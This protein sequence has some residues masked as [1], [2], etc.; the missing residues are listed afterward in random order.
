LKEFKMTVN[1]KRDNWATTGLWL[2]PGVTGKVTYDQPDSRVV[3]QIG[4]HVESLLNEGNPWKRWPWVITDFTIAM[5]VTEVGTPF[6]GILYIIANPISDDEE[7]FDAD[8]T[9]SNFC[10]FPRWVAGSPQVW[11]ETK[12]LE[13]PWGE[14]DFGN[15][16]FTLPTSYMREIADF[17][18]IH[19]KY[20]AIVNG[21]CRWMSYT[22]N[23]PYRIVFDIEL[24]ADGPG[25]AYPS[26]L[27]LSAIKGVLLT[28]ESPNLDLFKAISLMAINSIREE[29]FD[30]VLET[31][32]AS[33]CAAVVFKELYPLFSPLRFPDLAVPERFVQLWKIHT[34]CDPKLIP[35]CLAK[36][37]HPSFPVPE[38]QE[39]VWPM[40][41][42]E[43]CRIGN[44]NF[45]PF[46]EETLPEDF[47]PDAS[48]S[49]LPK[50]T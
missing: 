31:A 12:A 22:P 10:K 48:I 26:V 11:E 1:V 36:F 21:V 34:E 15:I 25:F 37:Q 32:I 42:E 50:Y 33:M 13:V 45:V 3:L 20:D 44:K 9:F 14:I 6:G 29:C 18:K 49:V 40:F 24:P 19:E 17:R 43:M 41:V 23:K 39:D 30:V 8:L 27:L 2:P 4:A 47:V 46:L 16:I 7:P 28:I 35:A 5:G 38:D